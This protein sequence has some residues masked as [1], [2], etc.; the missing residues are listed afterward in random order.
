MMRHFQ[1][2]RYFLPIDQTPTEEITNK[3]LEMLGA[4]EAIRREL[5][6]RTPA[7][8]DAARKNLKL[9]ADFLSSA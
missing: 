5:E 1:I 3:V 9:L 8:R 6:C 2:S 4:R 7:M